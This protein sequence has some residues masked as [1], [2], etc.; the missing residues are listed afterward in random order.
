VK[1]KISEKITHE[2][3]LLSDGLIPGLNVEFAGFD[4]IFA[5]GLLFRVLITI[6]SGKS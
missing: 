4:S 6:V 3:W 1:P 2:N 5:V